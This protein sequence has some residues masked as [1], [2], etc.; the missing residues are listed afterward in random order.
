MY[1]RQVPN[2]ADRERDLPPLLGV[3]CPVK[4]LN[5]VAGMPYVAGS[6]ALLGNVADVDDGVVHRL[7]DAGAIVV[8][9]TTTP[10]FGFPCY[11]A[12]SYTHLD[13]YKRQAR[14]TRCRSGR[15]WRSADPRGAP[16]WRPAWDRRTGR[17]HWW[18]SLIH[19]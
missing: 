10:E 9:K 2:R 12:V 15:S 17:T 1:K 5:P 16:G 3:P 18:L 8:G 7:R 14:P 13:V 19:I 6:R 11:T 4:D